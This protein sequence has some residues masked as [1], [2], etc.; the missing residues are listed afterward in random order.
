VDVVSR[1]VLGA[2]VFRRSSKTQVNHY[3]NTSL[4]VAGASAV[5]I[6]RINQE[7]DEG[8]SFGIMIQEDDD[9]S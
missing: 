9:R 7:K 1:C 2:F 3:S 6:I 4:S 5:P 8:I